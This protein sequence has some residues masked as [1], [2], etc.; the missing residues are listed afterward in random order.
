MTDE[1]NDLTLELTYVCPTCH[2]DTDCEWIRVTLDMQDE[3]YCLYCY[4]EWI[5]AHVPKLVPKP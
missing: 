1:K 3:R 5:R 2:R 4:A